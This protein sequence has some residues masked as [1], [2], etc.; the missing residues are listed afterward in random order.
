MNSENFITF[1]L[2]KICSP[3]QRMSILE[4]GRS[5][6]N[7]HNRGISLKKT[8]DQFFH[9]EVLDDVG[10]LEWSLFYIQLIKITIC[11]LQQVYIYYLEHN[12]KWS[13][14]MYQVPWRLHAVPDQAI[15]TVS[16]ESSCWT[17]CFKHKS[18]DSDKWPKF[19]HKFMI[20]NCIPAQPHTF[21][22]GMVQ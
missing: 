13:P 17:D 15:L 22:V 2:E 5:M 10:G 12:Q 19:I 7:F 21:M 8:R 3:F 18:C 1:V 20:Q 11:S 6:G 14:F 4:G 16:K 9:G